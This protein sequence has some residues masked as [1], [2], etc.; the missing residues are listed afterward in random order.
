MDLDTLRLSRETTSRMHRPSA[1]IQATPSRRFPARYAA[2]TLIQLLVVV[3]II[4]S[5]ALLAPAL[6]AQTISAQQGDLIVGFRATGGMGVGVNLEVDLGSISNFYNGANNSLTFSSLV[7]Q[8]LIDVYGANWGTRTD[9]F[10]GAAATDGNAQADPNGKLKSTLWATG[11]PGN[12]VPTV[13]STGLQQP[14][15]TKMG[16]LY[17]GGLGSLNGATSTTNSSGAADIDNTL[18][19][20]WSIQETSGSSF[21]FFNPKIDGQVSSQ[22]TLN[23]YELQPSSTFPRPASTLLGSLTLAQNG[24]SYQ[25][26]AAASPPVAVFSGSP[27]SGT[28]PLLVTFTNTST[29]TITSQAWSF[30]DGGTSSASNPTYTYTTAGVYTV[31]LT[32]YGPGGSNTLTQAGYI[33]AGT[34]AA[35]VAAFSASPTNGA[36]PLTVNFADNSTGTITNQEWSF[37]DGGVTNVANPSYTYT[38][39]GVYTVALTVYGPG[40]SN[41]LT[42]AGYVVAGATTAPVAAFSGSPTNGAAPL[43]VNFVDNSTGTITN[44]GWSFGDGGTTTTA[45]PTNLSYTYNSPGVY[46]VS[47]TVHGPGGTNTLTQV[48]YVAVG[49]TNTA[50]PVAAFSGSPTNG[51]APLAVTFV[52]NSTG[53]ITNQTWSF[54]DGGM[55]NAA[56]PSHTYTNAGVYA[57]TLTV[58]GPGGSNALTQTGY[59][60][61]A[62]APPVAAFSGTPTNGAAPLTVTFVNNSTGAITNQMWSFGDGGTSSASSPAHAYTTAGVFSV[63]LSVFGPGGSNTLSLANLVTVTSTNIASSPP[64]LRVTSPTDFQA[65][66]NSSLL[67]VGTASDA[68]GIKSVA[69]NGVPAFVLG[70]NWFTD[71]A[72]VQG[73]NAIAVIATDNSPAMDT[74]T[75]VVFA[76]LLPAPTNQAPVI[77]SAPAVTNALLCLQDVCVVLA[78]ETN[79]F[80]VEATDP[81]N[82]T[83]S[84]TWDFGDGASSAASPNK[85]AGHVYTNCGPYDASVTVDDGVY[86]TNASLTVSVPCTL[87]ISSLKLQANF[88][89]T[90]SDT[91]TIKATFTGMSESFSVSNAAVTLDVGGATAEIQLN[92]AG[93][94][95]NRNGNARFSLNKKTDVWT[96]TGG[97]KGDLKDSWETYG[98]TSNAVR[99]SAVTV[100]VLLIL[101]TNTVESFYAEPPLNYNNP[102]GKSG[103]A[104]LAP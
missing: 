98:V 26:A 88:K 54:G 19:G 57:V 72:L 101:Q 25:A 75:Q 64:V 89:K 92:K 29:G 87:D 81:N 46:T 103:T 3:T 33:T 34:P 11:V 76:V 41:T 56:S 24:L 95:A 104:A 59:V 44:E 20:S 84:Y 14:A 13:G 78:G 97:L 63:S 45:S 17:Q 10:W 48:N 18:A 70:T 100:P 53:T 43:T 47:L 21:G 96:F 60:V 58:Y 6:Q 61:V 99:N 79:V 38:T 32:V 69:V 31:A 80:S 22:D 36:A 90:G 28:A 94:G 37:G 39:A 9:L 4:G 82:L 68:S 30:G 12:T 5:G 49:P 73:T 35:P 16:E 62:A 42:Q 74:S 67:V 40:G 23:L 1:L 51:V 83:L 55:T 8:D 65:Y 66:T 50:T 93:T 52:D 85:I 2:F 91:C 71:I 102:S 7:A 15:A 77:V 86:S 27:S